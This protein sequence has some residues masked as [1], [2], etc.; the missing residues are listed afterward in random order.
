MNSA[1][2][3]ESSTAQAYAEH[4]LQTLDCPLP[5]ALRT[6]NEHPALSWARSGLMSLTG[7]ADGAPQ[8]CP[9]SL[10][11]CA[12]GALAA[13]ASLAPAQALDGL[14]GS[15]LLA[16][17]A[18]IAGHRRAGASSAAGNCR[19]LQTLDGFIALNL[20]RDDDWVLLPAWLERETA[21]AQTQD[22]AALQRLLRN[23][24][25]HDLVERG[26]LL[27]LAVCPRVPLPTPAVL[28]QRE[29]VRGG[30]QRPRTRRVPRV[31]DLSSLW[32]GPLCSHLLQR[33][34]ADV[35]KVESTQRPDGARHGPAAFFDLLNA[36]K[37]SVALDFSSA[38][39]REC[40]RALIAQADVV[41]E[42]SR[43]RAL[44][45]LGIDA[46]S[47]VRSQPG[48]IWL[49]IS[50]YGRGGP[51]EN[52]LAYGDDAGVAAGLS[53][54]M[55]QVTGESMFVGDA[56]AD[57]LT[58]LHAALAAWA[59]WQS[60]A[61]GLIALALCDVVRHCGQF[62]RPPNLEALRQRQQQWQEIVREV[63]VA[64]CPPQARVASAAAPALGADTDAVLSQWH[65]AC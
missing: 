42:A 65:A 5:R 18:A 43:P 58:G 35:V 2:F 57:P 55:Q 63:G 54:V 47:I 46:E 8:M 29:I 17:R 9:L 41:I 56:I 53:Y 50:G 60:G 28:W 3:Q 16:E 37:R 30:L 40:L 33:L 39:G 23:C 36:G 1:A 52:W 44:R 64:A 51:Q 12:D 26:R 10:A 22:W 24:T 20:A 4:L 49:S 14:S 48:L 21:A 25:M 7:R 59:R 62:R 27:G 11:A 15:R 31:L 45:Q 13:L 19:L 32:A 6:A 34:G 38:P 61:G